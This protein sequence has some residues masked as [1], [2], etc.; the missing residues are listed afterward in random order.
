MAHPVLQHV[1]LATGLERS[2]V[3]YKKFVILGRSRTG[4]NFLRGLLASRGGVIVLGEIFKNPERVEWGTKGFPVRPGAEKLYSK[5]P[6]AFLQKD[7]FRSVPRGTEA[8]GFKLFYYHAQ[9][10][11]RRQIWEHLRH[12][13]DVH[14]IHIMRR[15][16][17][18]THLSR[19][20][21]SR[22]DEWV[23]LSRG[24]R[25]EAPLVLSAEDCLEQFQQTRRWEKEFGDFFEGVP[26][27]PVYY[28]DLVEDSDRIMADVQDF[29]GLEIRPV[30][31]LTHK[32]AR[33]PISEAI[34]NFEELRQA[35]RGTE[36]Q[37]FFD[38]E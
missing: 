31:P 23:S 3:D 29:L 24:K 18:K 37:A 8:V 2:I 38:T 11:G 15:N 28:E 33:R 22:N 21:G 4:S 13:D 12:R 10:Q 35:F 7:V 5:D 16:I 14:I 9:S 36:W 20:L 6:V 27:M 26:L 32:Q 34:A 19:E 30:V 1:M 25:E 17:L